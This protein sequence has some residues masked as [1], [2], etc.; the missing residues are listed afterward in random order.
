M[1][2]GIQEVYE[3]DDIQ[4]IEHF[5][6]T[7]PVGAIADLEAKVDNDII[8]KSGVDFKSLQLSPSESAT[9][10]AGKSLSSK[11]R[12]NKNI[13]DNWFGFF[14]RL[15]ELRMA[16]IQQLHMMNNIRVPIEWGSITNKW[17]FEPDETWSFGSGIIWAEFTKWEFMVMPITETMLGN[18]KQRRK[19]N[20]S[21]FMQ[22]AWN[23]LWEDGKPVIKW[24]QLAKLASEEY[25]YDYEKLTEENEDSQSTEDIVNDVFWEW[26]S[27][28]PEEDP[29]SPNYVPPAQRS[30]KDQVKTISWQAKIQDTDLADEI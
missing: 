11:K 7:V 2:Y 29:S 15:G 1:N 21:T 13:K 17:I 3:T 22:V 8:A 10:T 5:A 19:E 30:Q 28:A 23:L 14:R 25:G 27:T 16:N 4:G 12:I 9:K 20:L 24:T 18:N 26:A 6:P